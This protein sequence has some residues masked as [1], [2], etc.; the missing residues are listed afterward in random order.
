MWCIPAMEG[1]MTNQ[2]EVGGALVSVPRF[3]TCMEPRLDDQK[4]EPEN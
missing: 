3:Q 4:K 2:K 1:A